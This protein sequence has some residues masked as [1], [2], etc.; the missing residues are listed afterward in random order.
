MK[1]TTIKPA[2][3]GGLIMLGAIPASQA[4]DLQSGADAR[5]LALTCAGCHG[6][7]GSSLGPAAPTISGMHPDYFIDIMAGFAD[8]EIYSTVMGRIARGYSEEEIE[9][10]AGYFHELPYVPANQAFDAELV[11]TGRRL[12]DKYCEKCHMEGGTPVEDEEYY[13]T[14]GQWLP[15]LK[16]A[17]ADFRED[18]RPIE[19]KMKRKLDRMLER[20]GEESLDALYA[21]YASQQ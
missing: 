3:L 9:L 2:L 6:T 8:G 5:T 13:I 20:D 11:E 12:H 17:M 21:F 4:A 18:R 16:N 14:A 15:Y 7:N 19:R 1:E 10:M